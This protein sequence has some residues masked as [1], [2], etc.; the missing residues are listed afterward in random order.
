MNNAHTSKQKR[1]NNNLRNWK[2]HP[3]VS[4]G[5][6]GDL[7]EKVF[8]AMRDFPHRLAIT[9][10]YICSLD[11]LTRLIPKIRL[12]KLTL[13]QILSTTGAKNLSIM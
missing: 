8:D 3:R 13:I 9:I 10:N 5:D 7:K 2:N 12:T 6:R 11:R 1:T 4:S